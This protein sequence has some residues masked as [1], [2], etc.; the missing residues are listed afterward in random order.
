MAKTVVGVFDRMEDA[1]SVVQELVQHGVSRGAIS[2]VANDANGT[3]QKTVGGDK[4]DKGEGEQAGSGAIAGAGVGGV[5]GLLVG[6]GA[7]AI[8]GIGPVIAAGPIAAAL[9]STALGAGLGAA[10]GGLVGP[11]VEAGVPRPEAEQYSESVRRGGTL[12]TVQTPDEMVDDTLAI[13]ERYNVVDVDQRGN[14]YREGGWKGFSAD[15]TPMTHDDIMRERTMYTQPV[16]QTTTTTTT[17]KRPTTNVRANDN[18][19]VLP[20]IEE[21]INVGKRDVERGRAR[22][23]TVVTERP[24]EEQVQL[25]EERVVV[26]RRPVDR[27]VDATD[28]AFVEQEFEMTE[29]REQAVIDKQARVVEEVVISKQVEERTETV[30]DTVRRTD[31]EVDRTAA[32]TTTGTT[33]GTNMDDDSA[34]FRSY[35]DKSLTKSGY[36]YDQY[37]PVFT[38]GSTLASTYKGRK[39]N[40]IEGDVR[41][42]W[43]TKNSGTW[44]QFKDSIKFAWDRATNR[45]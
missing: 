45:H 19:T 13:M 2:L 7:L 20:V 14:M 27:A 36:T 23:H 26:D 12:V 1:Q 9:G 5:V 3:M 40:D 10:A 29:R 22:V 17:E 42:D 11:L 35:Y 37:Q 8:P 18:D 43:E 39:W 15:S 44:E 32:T 31:V 6:L 21:T 41:R 16:A 25:R 33:A 24:V 34:Y 28:K 4:M 38:Y 30:R